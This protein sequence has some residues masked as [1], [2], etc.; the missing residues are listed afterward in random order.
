[1]QALEHERLRLP[2]ALDTPQIR[3]RLFDASARAGI[4]AFELRNRAIYAKDVVGVIAVPPLVVEILPKIHT[5][6]N[7]N[8]ASRFL[9]DLLRFTASHIGLAISDAFL[10]EGKHSLLEAIL[11][12]A[13]QAAVSNIRLAIPRRYMGRQETSTAIRGKI[14]LHDVARARPGKKFEL[15]VRYAPL[16]EDNPITRIIRWLLIKISQSTHVAS[17]RS[18]CHR[19]LE[20]LSRVA[21]IV[22][23]A[24]DFD[25]IVL[26]PLEEQWSPLIRLAR[27]LALNSPPDPTRSGAIA[28]ISVLFTLHDLFELALRRILREHLF[29]S[30]VRLKPARKYLLYPVPNDGRSPIMR[31]VPDFGFFAGGGGLLGVGDAKWK[32]IF[33]SESQLNITQQDIYQLT[34]YM[35]AFCAGVGFLFCPLIGDGSIPLLH[36]S[37]TLVGSKSSVKIIGVHAPTLIAPTAVGEALRKEFCSLVVSTFHHNELT[38]LNSA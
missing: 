33:Q 16:S 12:W 30:P 38:A 8:E 1:V 6:N 17:T 28:S 19:A 13:V 18:Q 24:S 2:R 27:S 29:S 22:P 14:E 34:S 36:S 21:D 10:S 31:L 23:T 9:I 5:A 4:Q 3:E 20:Y 26:Q 25:R 15:S 37:W 11:S 35:T 7:D 32:I